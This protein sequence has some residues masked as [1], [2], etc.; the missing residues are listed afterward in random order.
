MF[1]RAKKL[2]AKAELVALGERME[3]R[4]RELIGRK[5]S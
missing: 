2:L 4:K 1:P 5:R 3:Q